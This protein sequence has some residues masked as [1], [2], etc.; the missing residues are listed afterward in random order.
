MAESKKTEQVDPVEN[1]IATSSDSRF[2]TVT[3]SSDPEIPSDA[4]PQLI[5][6]RGKPKETKEAV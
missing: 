1:V 4:G 3:K 6:E 2:S 5:E